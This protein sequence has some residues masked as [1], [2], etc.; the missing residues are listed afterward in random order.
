M[1][2]DLIFS[3]VI[4]LTREMVRKYYNEQA[5]FEWRRLVQDAYHKLEFETTLRFLK[6]YLPSE[7]L[8]LD[9]G[10]GPGRYTIE[11]AKQGYE[12]ILFDFSPAS[13][14]KAGRQIR[15]AKVQDQVKQITEGT[16]T[17]MGIFKD[18]SFDAV[19]CLGGTLGHILNKIHR[20]QAIDE[21]IRVTK[22]RAPLFVS[23]I[24]R[25]A[26]FKA[27]LESFPEELRHKELYLKILETGNYE[28]GHGF[29]ATH[30]FLSEELEAI[31]QKKSVTILEMVGLEGLASTHRKKLIQLARKYP[32]IWKNWQE[33]HYKTCTHPHVVGT[34][35]HFMIICQKS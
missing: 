16:I 9:A 28:G 27:A 12:V 21:L 2:Q 17:D 1:F 23:V 7:G 30:F 14:K 20:D 29:T 32:K 3:V 8:I 19:L 31:F 10:G 6:K 35:E 22:A 24:G 13:L 4:V 26:L 33:Y 15:R 25:L 5:Q 34:S 18:G 11:L